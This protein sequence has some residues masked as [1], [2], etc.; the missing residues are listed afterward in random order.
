MTSLQDCLVG[1]RL[2][3]LEALGRAFPILSVAGAV[4]SADDL[5]EHLAVTLPWMLWMRAEGIRNDGLVPTGSAVLPFS[6]YVVFKG[7]DHTALVSGGPLGLSADH[8]ALLTQALLALVA[9]EATA[10]RH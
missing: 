1:E 7:T 6:D 9:G 2:D 4:D 3:R 10:T 5:S 8:R